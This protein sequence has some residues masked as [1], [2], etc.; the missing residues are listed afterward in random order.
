MQQHFALPYSDIP[1]YFRKCEPWHKKYLS[2]LKLQGN[3][4]STL[5]LHHKYLRSN[6]HIHTYEIHKKKLQ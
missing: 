5:N 1:L 4:T 6:A 2:S 3:G